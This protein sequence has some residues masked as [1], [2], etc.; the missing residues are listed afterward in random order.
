MRAF[1]RP[2]VR[3]IGPKAFEGCSELQ[4]ISLPS[5]PLKISDDA[6]PKKSLHKHVCVRTNNSVTQASKALQG[7]MVRNPSAGTRC[8]GKTNDPA[9]PRAHTPA[10]AGRVSTRTTNVLRVSV[11]FPRR[12][13]ER[14]TR[15]AATRIRFHGGTGEA[16]RD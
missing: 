14:G 6:F 8:P 7:I 11:R 10:H 1:L 3:S 16:R 15:R 13:P 5:T 4:L 2:S 9:P 12:L